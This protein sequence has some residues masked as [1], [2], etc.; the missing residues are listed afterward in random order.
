MLKDANNPHQHN[1]FDATLWDYLDTTDPLIHL[2]Q[3]INWSAIEEKLSPY[4]TQNNGR[5]ALPIRLMAGLLILKQSENLSDENLVLQWKRNPYFQYFCGA[6]S[7]QNTLPCHATELV[8]FRQR[9]GTAGVDSIF[10]ASVQLHDQAVEESVVNIDTTVQEKN[11]T[12]PTDGKLAIKIINRLNKIAKDHGIKQR[13]TFIKEV[14]EQR[15]K[16]R[17]FRHVKKR[18][19]AKKAV[20]RLRTIVGILQRE[21]IRKLDQAS[22]AF[23]Q[24]GF[25]LYDQVVSQQKSD[26]DKIY[27]LHEPQVYCVA[28]GKRPQAL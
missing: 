5:P 8:K 26:H 27:S 9:I 20:K 13:R 24:H 16:L 23:Y 19:S 21:L 17:F 22:L 6:N 4:Y 12:Y 7:F 15:L 3:A 2:A 25:E 1:F 18:A 14:K 28:K 10:H 11:I